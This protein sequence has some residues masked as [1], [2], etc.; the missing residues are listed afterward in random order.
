MKSTAR[1][2]L[3]ESIKLKVLAERAGIDSA[4][5]SRIIHNRQN[6]SP[7]LAQKLADCANQLTGS[8]QFKPT[9]FL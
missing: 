8:E 5:L 7:E 9:D 6:L 4:S 3:K 1:T 2:R